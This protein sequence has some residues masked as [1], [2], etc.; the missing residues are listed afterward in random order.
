MWRFK[1]ASEV[2]GITTEYLWVCTLNIAVE[3]VG[4]HLSFCCKFVGLHVFGTV[5]FCRYY[6]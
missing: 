5:L 4:E 2:V 1:V 3:C 6:M